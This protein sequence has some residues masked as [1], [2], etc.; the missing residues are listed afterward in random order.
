MCK[1]LQ[2]ANT[3]CWG[4]RGSMLIISFSAFS[5]ASAIA[6]KPLETKFIDKI[7][8]GKRATGKPMI[9]LSN[10]VH[11]SPELDVIMYLINFRM[12]S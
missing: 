4:I 5:L 10:K 7:C 6:G 8:I 12:L 9:T 2:L 1:P 11:N 3:L